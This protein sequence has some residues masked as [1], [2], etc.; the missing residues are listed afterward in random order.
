MR[1]GK[2]HSVTRHVQ[3][4]QI[5]PRLCLY[6]QAQPALRKFCS[7]ACRQAAYRTRP[8]HRANLDKQKKVRLDRRNRH[9]EEKVRDKALMF[10]GTFSGDTCDFLPKLGQFERFGKYAVDAP[11]VD[12]AAIAA[13]TESAKHARFAAAD[14]RIKATA[15]Q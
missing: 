13:E 3:G 2:N 10:D 1:S 7:S 14:A 15:T 12:R 5:D 6:C 9:T 8:A 11:D 4:G